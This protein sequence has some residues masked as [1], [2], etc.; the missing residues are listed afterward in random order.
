[1]SEQG[2]IQRWKKHIVIAV[3]LVAALIAASYYVYGMLDTGQLNP[4]ALLVVA[5]TDVL[6]GIAREA[7]DATCRGIVVAVVKS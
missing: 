6:G 2:F 5:V 4:V 1:M 3:T 7:V